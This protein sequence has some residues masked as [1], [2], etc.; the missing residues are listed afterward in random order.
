M[1]TCGIGPIIRSLLGWVDSCITVAITSAICAAQFSSGKYAS[2]TK[3]EFRDGNH[4]G[5]PALKRKRRSLHSRCATKGLTARTPVTSL[6]KQ[7]LKKARHMTIEM[8]AIGKTHRTFIL[9]PSAQNLE[10]TRIRGISC[11]PRRTWWKNRV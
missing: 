9:T 5:H 2:R 10:Y 3:A 6:G 8:V 7:H 4:N 1:G 11:S